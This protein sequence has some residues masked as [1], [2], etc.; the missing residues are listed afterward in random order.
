MNNSPDLGVLDG[1]SD[2]YFFQGTRLEIS[3]IYGSFG[4]SVKVMHLQGSMGG[5][6]VELLHYALG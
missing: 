4:G 5:V 6:L 2:V 3:Y 1:A